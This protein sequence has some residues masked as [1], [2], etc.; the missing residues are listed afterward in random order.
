MLFKNTLK[1]TMSIYASLDET[2]WYVFS[3]MLFLLTI[4]KDSVSSSSQAVQCLL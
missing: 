4:N 2:L 3:V 1:R